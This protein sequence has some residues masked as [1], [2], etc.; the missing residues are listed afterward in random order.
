M[1]I[2]SPVW[3]SREGFLEGVTIG[4]HLPN[5]PLNRCLSCPMPGL[6]LGSRV[7]GK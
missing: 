2:S 4:I 6:V 5:L 1:T 3:D 7:G